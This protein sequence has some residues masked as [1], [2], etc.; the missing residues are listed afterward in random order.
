MPSLVSDF[1]VVDPTNQYLFVP[2]G[3]AETPNE[4]GIANNGTLASTPPPTAVAS[5]VAFTPGGDFAIM[6]HRLE[7]TVTSYSLDAAGGLSAINTV[8]TGNF[9]VVAIVDGSGKFGYG[10]CD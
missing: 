8:P 3:N 6:P 2:S 9:P 1:L 4:F 10:V 7:N 5:S